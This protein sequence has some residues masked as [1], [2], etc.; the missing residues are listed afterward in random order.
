MKLRILYISMESKPLFPLGDHC[1]VQMCKSLQEAKELLIIQKPDLFVFHCISDG[2][3]VLELLRF[4]HVLQLSIPTIVLSSTIDKNSAPQV[5]HE[6]TF[7]LIDLTADNAQARFEQSVGKVTG[8]FI[9]KKEK[10]IPSPQNKSDLD[11]LCLIGLII[12]CGIISA[13]NFIS[14]NCQTQ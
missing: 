7:D 13:L 9:E 11:A 8:L 6:G 2:H 12:P 1:M 10:P 14:F 4:L 3:N 5:L